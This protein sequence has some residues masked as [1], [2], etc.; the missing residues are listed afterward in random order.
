[1]CRIRA[2]LNPPLPFAFQTP[3][4][5][6]GGV[7][8]NKLGAC[9]DSQ[10]W[11]CKIGSSGPECFCGECSAY[12]CANGAQKNQ[13]CKDNP[14][15]GCKQAT[16]S[17]CCAVRGELLWTRVLQVLPSATAAAWPLNIPRQFLTFVQGCG[18]PGTVG[19]PQCRYCDGTSC[20]FSFQCCN[21]S[22]RNPNG[23]PCCGN[24]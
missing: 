3:A 9:A 18:S 21:C 7:C 24:K 4:A 23:G 12:E 20:V 2:A 5:L 6:C 1:M 22:N 13:V 11:Q 10:Q 8:C 15:G 16:D 14:P 17:A 19:C